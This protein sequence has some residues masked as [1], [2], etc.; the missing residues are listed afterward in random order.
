MKLCKGCVDAY[1]SENDVHDKQENE[2][3]IPSMDVIKSSAL[4]AYS[5]NEVVTMKLANRNV[6]LSPIFRAVGAQRTFFFKLID[7]PTPPLYWYNSLG[8]L[9]NHQK[10][11]VVM[12]NIGNLDFLISIWETRCNR[13]VY[14]YVVWSNGDGDGDGDGDV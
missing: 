11:Y 1:W 8:A 3:I 12:C 6:S 2:P 10:C 9:V 13:P 4:M 7:D 14:H 5:K